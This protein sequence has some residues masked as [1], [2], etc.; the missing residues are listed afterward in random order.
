MNRRTLALTLAALAVCAAAC[1]PPAPDTRDYPTRIQAM[2]TA[3]DSQF[4]NTADPV[5]DNRKSQL[6]PL[7]YFPI[8]PAYNVPAQLKPSGDNTIVLMPASNGELR[9]ER[10]AGTL[11]FTLKGRQMTLSAFVEA[12][13][14]DVN[15]LF[16]PFRDETSGAETYEAG[17]YLDLERTATGIYELDFNRAYNPYCYYN[18]GYSC[19]Y[20]PKENHLDV[21]IEAGEKVRSHEVKP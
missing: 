2:R 18:L 3:K 21:R 4:Q 6:L 12:D 10:R 8:D 13:A 16:V 15:S 7:L 19:P 20:P 5:P 11:E 17:R 14:K 9:R 1:R